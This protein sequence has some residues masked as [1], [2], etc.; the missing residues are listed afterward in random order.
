MNTITRRFLLLA[1]ALSSTAAP[2][3]VSP[4]FE[5]M[6]VHGTGESIAKYKGKAVALYLFNP[7]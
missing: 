6:S 2:P 5:F 4:A 7:G 3:A 1:T